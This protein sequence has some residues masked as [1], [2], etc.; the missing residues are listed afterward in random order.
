MLPSVGSVVQGW[1]PALLNHWEAFIAAEKAMDEFFQIHGHPADIDSAP[2]RR[3]LEAE[4]EVFQILSAAI[5]QD[6]IGPLLQG[7]LDAAEDRE[8]TIS[9]I[10][11]L[12]L[13]AA[14]IILEWP[15]SPPNPASPDLPVVAWELAVIPAIGRME[16]LGHFTGPDASRAL[17]EQGLAPPGGDIVVLG[18]STPDLLL[19]WIAV[20]ANVMS[21]REHCMIA[22]EQRPVSTGLPLLEIPKE[23]SAQTTFGGFVYV[24]GIV[25]RSRDARPAP[26]PIKNGDW[27]EVE[28][29][30][31]A[32]RSKW[33]SRLPESI[34]LTEPEDVWDGCVF[35][36]GATLIQSIFVQHSIG[37]EGFSEDEGPVFAAVVDHEKETLRVVGLFPD[38]ELVSHP[39]DEGLIALF[40]ALMESSEFSFVLVEEADLDAWVQDCL[41]EEE[42]AP[43]YPPTSRRLS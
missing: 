27:R 10:Y 34:R 1:L 28:E 31:L 14:E 38:G 2:M 42:P 11:R 30:W 18:V 29:A 40:P 9:M 6:V 24:L 19:P 25:S 21:W 15:A 16:D 8:W 35:T 36:V 13:K 17:M 22:P 5:D 33:E 32:I 37:G 23:P 3:H 26:S 4:E 39:L 12:E 41:G 20:P 43:R 7:M